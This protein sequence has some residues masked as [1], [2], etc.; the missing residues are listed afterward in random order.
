M[1]AFLLIFISFLLCDNVISQDFMRHKKKNDKYVLV[2]KNDTSIYLSKEYNNM[3]DYKNGGIAVCIDNKWGYIDSTDKYIIS[4]IY[5]GVGSWF[6]GDGGDFTTAKQNGKWGL[7][8]RKGKVVYPF[9]A[10]W[11][12]GF[13][14]G[15]S[16][17]EINDKYGFINTKLKVFV[18]PKYDNVFNIH[19]GLVSVEKN[20]KWGVLDGSGKII[21]PL[22]YDF[23]F[24]FY[25]GRGQVELNKKFGYFDSR[26]KLVIPIIYD[27]ADPYFKDGQAKVILSGRTFYIDK[28]GNELM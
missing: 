18:K 10:D 4:P 3:G 6:C 20:K 12:I 27:K 2:H 8:D 1:K 26:G 21:V 25:E 11:A 24:E 16:P 28:K 5:E 15:F 19:D 14:D 9:L 22:K 23:I 13:T 7:V 17:Y